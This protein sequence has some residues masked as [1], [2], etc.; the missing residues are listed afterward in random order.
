MSISPSQAPGS[1]LSHSLQQQTQPKSD[2]SL[3]GQLQTLTK[4]IDSGDLNRIQNTYE[5]LKTSLPANTG[6]D[7][8]PV[9]QFLAAVANG[10]ESKDL[11]SLQ[12]AA[13]T[14]TETPPTTSTKPAA[15]PLLSEDS[16]SELT[17]LIKALESNNTESAQSSYGSLVTTL[18]E[19]G[20]SESTSL[21]NALSQVGDALQNGDTEQARSRLQQTLQ[22]LSPGSLIV[23]EA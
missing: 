10:L 18:N 1:S 16:S 7:N 12:N 20:S 14:F 4:A 11:S 19:N 17:K 3:S 6:N 13:D 2:Q 23:A 8:D 22:D 21:A 15:S 5:N 9:G